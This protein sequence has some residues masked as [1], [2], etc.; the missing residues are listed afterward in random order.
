MYDISVLSLT[1]YYQAT[2]RFTC[3]H[4]PL[5]LIQSQT[6]NAAFQYSY[7]RTIKDWNHLPIN[8][9]V[10]KYFKL[11]WLTIYQ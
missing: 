7:P 2:Q 8:L 6:N 10:M 9:T 3:H 4:H 11:N 5:H 1:S